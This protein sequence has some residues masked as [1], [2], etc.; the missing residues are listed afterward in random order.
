MELFSKAAELT[1]ANIPFAMAT[2]VEASGST[3]RGKAKMLVT[4]SGV[5]AGTVGGGA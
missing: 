3:P 5:V 2:I 4:A 1:A